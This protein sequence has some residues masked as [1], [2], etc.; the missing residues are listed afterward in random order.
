MNRINQQNKVLLKIK[1]IL[2]ERKILE[3][4]MKKVSFIKKIYKTDAN[5]ILIKVD[6]SYSSIDTNEIRVKCCVIPS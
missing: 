5:F 3:R 2:K 6:N 1:I 4:K